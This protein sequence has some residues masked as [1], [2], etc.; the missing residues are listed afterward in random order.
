MKSIIAIVSLLLILVIGVFILRPTPPV[1]AV[2]VYCSV[3]QVYAEP[4]LA[5]FARDTGIRVLPVF[6]VE[7]T[8]TTGL[9]T[10]L[11]AEKPHPRADVFWNNEFVNTLR[12]RQEGVL[13]PCR[14]PRGRD[15]PVQFVDPAGY[16]TGVG[17]RARVLLVNTRRLSPHRYPSAVRDLLDPRWPAKEVGL[18]VPLFG[19]T[20]THAAAL[21]ATL[22][23]ERA[24]DFFA[25]LK[26]RGVRLLDGNSVVRDKVVNGELAWGLTDSDDAL[27]ALA[28]GAPVAIV[29]PD[30][31]AGGTLALPGTVAL[32]AGAPHPAEGR[33]LVDF[34]AAAETE[35]ALIAAGGCQ[36]SLRD[37]AP[38][39]PGVDMPLRL[40]R[41]SPEAGL[42]QAPRA[43]RELREIFVR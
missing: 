19:T 16:W 1:C 9:A 18:A 6:D 30:Q 22:G 23:P 14:P 21:Y 37:A 33:A 17:G 29:P 25:R 38:R 36:F 15:L 24:R 32:I 13:A 4:I 26:A 28:Q 34:L 40:M 35:R 5:R 27:G 41:L 11:I 43:A 3:D 8:K 12:L 20:A 39:L 10:R 42:R 7:A 2:V 31:R